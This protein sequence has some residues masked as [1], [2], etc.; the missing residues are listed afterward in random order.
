MRDVVLCC[1]HLGFA[2]PR[3]DYQAGTGQEMTDVGDLAAFTN[4]ASVQ[5]RGEGQRRR[6]V[7]TERIR[8]S[9]LGHMERFRPRR[10]AVP[11][12]SEARYRSPAPVSQAAD[13]LGSPG[14]D[15]DTLRT[16]TREQGIRGP[17][18]LWKSSPSHPVLV[19]ERGWLR[20]VVGRR[21][22]CRRNR[23]QDSAMG[24]VREPG[25]RYAARPLRRFLTTSMPRE[26]CAARSAP[27]S[28]YPSALFSA[29]R[30]SSLSDAFTRTGETVPT[31]V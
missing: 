24:M 25:C 5:F 31:R 8:D 20:E 28:G 13:H 15:V 2:A 26:G 29:R 23:G 4:L 18:H 1:D 10:E 6:E 14:I 16:E 7:R 3:L 27:S 19:A 22:G 11:T 17:R 12:E 9:L 30:V 21:H